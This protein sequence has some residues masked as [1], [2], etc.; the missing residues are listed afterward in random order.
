M[1]LTVY[2]YCPG[3]INITEH[4]EVFP[5]L[6][7]DTACPGMKGTE[8]VL[9]QSELINFRCTH[10]LCPFNSVYQEKQAQHVR[11]AIYAMRFD[12]DGEGAAH[13]EDF[14][15]PEMH[16]K[17]HGLMALNVS[18]P[19]EP[20]DETLANSKTAGD[21]KDDV[22]YEGTAPARSTRPRGRPRKSGGSNTGKGV[23]ELSRKVCNGPVWVKSS[24]LG[25]QLTMPEIWTVDG[26]K[27]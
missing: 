15:D 25:F 19:I 7:A 11:E 22:D 10:N 6:R 14:N 17:E 8:R 5:C 4:D 18:S 12:Y 9:T 1:C 23:G 13:T 26:G 20:D 24:Q 2:S 21:A 16:D 3:C 27:E